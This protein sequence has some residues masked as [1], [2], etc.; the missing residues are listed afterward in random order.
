MVCE[1]MHAR[2][3]PTQCLFNQAQ[4]MPPC[5][6]CN[7]AAGPEEEAKCPPENEAPEA[8]ARKTY[9]PRELAKLAG[10]APHNIYDA[11]KF[12][13]SGHYVRGVKGA[14]IRACMEKHGISWDMIYVQPVPG[15]TDR[16][17][18]RELEAPREAPAAGLAEQAPEAVPV[19]AVPEAGQSPDT[20]VEGMNTGQQTMSEA[21]GKTANTAEKTAAQIVDLL[22]DYTAYDAGYIVGAAL[23]GLFNFK[24]GGGLVARIEYQNVVFGNYEQ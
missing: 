24:L 9:T 3:S 5:K 8:A 12:K 13:D 18:K 21:Q 4:N 19:E 6:G 11:L 20:P 17:S 1:R 10:V 7:L 14:K 23:N 22:R 16:K 15:K 2:I